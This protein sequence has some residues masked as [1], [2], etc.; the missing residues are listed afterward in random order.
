[1]VLAYAR[2]PFVR[3]MLVIALVAGLAFAAGS[4]YIA[5][6]D[7]HDQT[8]YACLYA[9][10][11]SQVNTNAPPANCGR[12][13]NV[14]WDGSEQVAL[15]ANATT[16]E[17]PGN[18]VAVDGL[19]SN[20]SN[21]NCLEGEVATGGGHTFAPVFGNGAYVDN[22]RAIPDPDD[23]AVGWTVTASGVGGSISS[24]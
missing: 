5:S 6:G 2:E 21:A 22:S 12:G 9:G 4:V 24:S 19:G 20:V 15:A 1:M 7:S 13:A 23:I 11:L 17:R 8:F 14:Q 16:I 18:T 10:S 3:V